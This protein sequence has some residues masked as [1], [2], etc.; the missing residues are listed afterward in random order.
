MYMSEYNYYYITIATKPHPILENIK[1]RVSNN[2]EQLY[3]LGTRENR[4]IG[5]NAY[6][7]FGVKL[8][9]V[10]NFINQSNLQ[11]NDII[12][13]TDA[14]DVIYT[15]NQKTIIERFQ[16]SNRPIL[17]G[18]ETECN[19]DPNM[20]EKYE[21]RD[22]QFPF[23]NSGMFIGRI[24]ALR[25]CMQDYTFDDKHD[26]QRFWTQKFFQYPE[27]IGLDYKNELFLN[28][29]GID[30][31]EIRWNRQESSFRGHNPQFI[32]VNGPNK[33]DLNNFI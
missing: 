13:F 12:L 7:N 30:I 29:Y 2:N 14:Y 26:D 11:E 4:P 5:W 31:E 25:K 10:H 6:G 18:S 1:K 15:G 21:K 3:V 19:P 27:L 23:L 24:W 8:R 17:F 20:R 33:C 16:K 22:E 28:T 9:E 32:H